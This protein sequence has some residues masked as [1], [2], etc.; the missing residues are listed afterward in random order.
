MIG[1]DKVSSYIM[2][3]I[4]K[5]ENIKNT[6]LYRI[7][8]EKL[9]RPELW[10][11]TQ[12]TMA[13]GLALGVFI[14]LTP[15]VGT[16]MLISGLAAYFLRVNIPVAVACAWITN[17]IT[18]PI[19]YP[20]QYKLGVLVCGNSDMSELAHY[21]NKIKTFIK[22]AKPLWIGSLIS[23]AFFGV[24][25]YVAVVFSWNFIEKMIEKQKSRCSKAD[26]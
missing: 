25:S 10:K 9:F 11:P 4:P 7:I 15:T 26:L 23:G 24:I 18:I 22:Y 16:Q 19:I 3:H 1:W 20:L 13:G 21:G 6:V 12:K 17:P 2:K 5:Q 14:A 8:G